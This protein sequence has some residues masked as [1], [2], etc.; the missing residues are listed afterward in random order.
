MRTK[1]SDCS[2]TDRNGYTWRKRYKNSTINIVLKTRDH[3]EAL[4]NATLMTMKFLEYSLTPN[5]DVKA[6]GILLKS[7]IQNG[8]PT[9]RSNKLKR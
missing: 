2:Y 4:K 6:I 5:M 9:S 3:N 8:K 7:I 1:I